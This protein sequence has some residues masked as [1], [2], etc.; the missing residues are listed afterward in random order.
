MDD[1]L[2]FFIP[3]DRA[4]AWH[5][6]QLTRALLV[7]LRYSPMAQQA[8]LQLV[9]PEKP[10]HTLSKAIFATQ[11]QRV[12]D[13]NAEITDSEVVHGISVYLTPDA[14]QDMPSIAASDRQQVLDGII[15]YG[16]DLVI[17]I[18]NKTEVGVPPVQPCHINLHGTS[19]VFDRK[20]RLVRWQELLGVLIDLVERDLVTGAERMLFS[21]FFDLVEKHFPRIGP[22]STL[23]RCGENAFR[24]RCRLD[25]IL[26]EVVGTD[27]GKE[28]GA[29]DLPGSGKVT[30]AW[31]GFE[32]SKV[33]LR[34]WPGD[35]LS[36]SRALYTDHISLKAILALRSDGWRVEPNFHWGFM[37]SGLAWMKTPLPVE[38]YCDYWVK[39]IGTTHELTRS[40]WK[41]YW[42]ELEDARMVE[43]DEKKA[44]DKYFTNTKRQ[45]AHPRPGL[46][47]EYN[48]SLLEAQQLDAQSKFVKKV[49]ERLNQILVTLNAPPLPTQERAGT[50]LRKS[51]E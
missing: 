34:I 5:E 39:K 37:A 24:R 7:V 51:G 26:G 44:F 10:L 22:Y 6:N 14:A 29:R 31:L 3:Y 19:I 16:N 17:V 41:D 47:C 15:N 43:R 20:P 28:K 46:R 9:A 32:D 50:A 23:A 25:G 2:N 1:H 13:T 38:K 40:E 45:S 18:E 11:R 33:S 42:V 36:Q 27:V 30:M 35:T 48:W 8:W 49:R 4:P 21:D 12:L